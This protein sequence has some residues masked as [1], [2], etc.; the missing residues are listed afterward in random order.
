MSYIWSDYKENTKYILALK[1]NIF[2]PFL[3][4]GPETNEY[5]HVNAL[6]R[7]RDIFYN[8]GQEIELQEEVVDVLFHLLATL[9]RCCGIHEEQ[10]EELLL[11]KQILNGAYGQNNKQDFCILSDE[12]KWRFLHYLRLQ[13]AESCRKLYFKEVLNSILPGNICYFDS[14]T[15]VLLVYVPFKKAPKTEAIVRLIDNF[16]LDVTT[17][18]KY[19]F[20]IPFGIIGYDDTLRQG[21]TLIY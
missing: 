10:V 15:Q 17:R 2:S 7:F 9:D 3:E 20:Q 11:Q 14:D 18:T 5:V 1:E 12:D 19:Y 16:F 13:N 21:Y 6:I 4:T 8:N